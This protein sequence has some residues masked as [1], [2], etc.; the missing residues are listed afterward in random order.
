LLVKAVIGKRSQ[1]SGTSPIGISVVTDRVQTPPIQTRG[2]GR[3]ASQTG[4]RRRTMTRD[5]KSF[6]FVRNEIPIRQA[7]WEMPSGQIDDH[8]ADD[9]QIKDTAL[10]EVREETG[11]EV[12]SKGELISLGFFFTGVYR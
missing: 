10:R 4:G 5:G 7:I 6:L 2:P 12:G 8:N 1:A 9:D 3:C 11:Y